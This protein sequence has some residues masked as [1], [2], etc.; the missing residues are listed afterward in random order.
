MLKYMHGE[1]KHFYC[2]KTLFHSSEQS[3]W[4]RTII[5][6]HP[7]P[8]C[9][10]MSSY[11]YELRDKSAL[12]NTTVGQHLEVTYHSELQLVTEHK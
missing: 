7:Y 2:I 9:N 1:G 11:E 12:L 8:N 3:L 5:T 6:S 4:W 10:T